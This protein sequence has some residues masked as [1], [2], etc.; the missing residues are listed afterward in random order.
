MY[1]RIGIYE[2]DGS[3]KKK[4]IDDIIAYLGDLRL[5]LSWTR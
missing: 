4:D 3:D 2:Y 1:W 5:I